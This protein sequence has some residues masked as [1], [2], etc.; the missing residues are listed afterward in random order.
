MLLI[1]PR[2]YCLTD[3]TDGMGLKDERSRLP[4]LIMQALSAVPYR[5]VPS[6]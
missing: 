1:Y 4:M 3:M 5:H 2:L 6:R